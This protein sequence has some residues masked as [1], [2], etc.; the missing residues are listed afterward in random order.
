MTSILLWLKNSD[1]VKTKSVRASGP[2]GQRTNRRSTK[3]QIWIKISDLPLSEKEKQLIR[4]KLAHRVNHEDELEVESEEERFQKRNKERA[5]EKL[6]ELIE[7]AIHKDPPR[8]QT[9]PPRSAEEQRMRH[10]HLRYQKKRSRREA[11]SGDIE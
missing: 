5:Y 1:E 8:I 6:S 7:G 10:K 2:G 11:K 9:E 3:V 4:E